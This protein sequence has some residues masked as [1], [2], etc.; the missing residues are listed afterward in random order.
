MLRALDEADAQARPYDISSLGLIVSSGVM[1]SAEVKEKLVARGNMFLLDSLGSSEAV[2]M[3]NSMSGP[4]AAA[5]TAHFTIGEDAKVFTDDGREVAPGS[6]EIGVLAVGGY[7]P[8]GYYKD[9]ATSASTFRVFAGRRWSVPGDFASV[10]ADGTIT[11]LG[12]GSVCI[13]SGGEKVFPEEVEEAVKRHPSVADAL[14]IGVPDERF[15]EAVVAVVGLRTGE[16]ADGDD[17]TG[18]LHDLARYKR[19]RNFVFVDTVKR[20]PNGKADYVWA[21]ETVARELGA[22]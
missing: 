14:V 20:G 15:G 21:K 2:G 12:R 7:I 5:A 11:L 9:E 6:D 17:I 3:A 1:W 18:A 4:G 13:N 19:P 10:D 8:A 22:R 16:Q